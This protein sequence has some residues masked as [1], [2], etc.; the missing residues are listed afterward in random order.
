MLGRPLLFLSSYA[1][2]FALLA[3]RF[4][5]PWLWI[6]CTLLAAVGVAA[7]WLLLKLDARSAPGP[8]VLTS[9]RDAGAEATAYL[10]SYL[11]PFLT[12][13]TPTPRDV[14][15]YT[16]FLLVAAVISLR[17]A[18]AQ[19]NPL[20]YLLGYRVLSVT[21]KNGLH[22]YVIAK[23]LIPEGERMLATRFRDDVLV[24]RS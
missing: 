10:A 24:E 7:L 5:P 1:P 15:A 4:E 23:R 16:G 11:L 21:D 22:A 14:L 3:I 18:V 8:H 20:L 19:V 12:L 13:P 17:S 9:V 2:L 6:P